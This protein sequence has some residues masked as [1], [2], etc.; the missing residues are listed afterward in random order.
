[1]IDL[2]ECVWTSMI[3]SLKQLDIIMDQNAWMTQ[4]WK[5]KKKSQ[6]PP[7]N[8][9]E[10]KHTTKENHQITK[11]KIKRRNEKSNYK[12]QWENRHKVISTYTSIITLNIN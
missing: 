11:W 6:T 7:Q 12:K 4:K 9:K 1:M 3:I 8:R 10:L 2:L 5:I